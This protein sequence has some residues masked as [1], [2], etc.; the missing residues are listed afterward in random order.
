MYEILYNNEILPNEGAI[1]N[2]HDA[3][4]DVYVAATELLAR[5]NN[6]F[7]RGIVEQT[8]NAIL[9]PEQAIGLISD[10]LEKEQRL[11]YEAQSCES[12]RNGQVAKQVDKEIKSLLAR[13]DG[14]SLPL[15]RID[16]RVARLLE[17]VE[18]K[19]LERLMDFISS[20]QFGKGHATYKDTRIQDTGDWLIAHESFQDWQAIASSSTLLCLKGTGR[21]RLT[22]Q[23]ILMTDFESNMNQ[24]VLVKHISHL[25]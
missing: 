14:V 7:G 20:E 5:S 22:K 10:L 25:V 11:S 1:Y 19:E 21:L 12:L 16:D 24:L 6:L 3:L 18:N 9:R 23:F 8:L 13:L 15:T 2:L 17:E 4:I